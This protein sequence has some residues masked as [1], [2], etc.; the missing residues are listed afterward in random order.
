M[1][2]YQSRFSVEGGLVNHGEIS[3]KKPFSLKT[4][5]ARD[6]EAL[7]TYHVSVDPKP[8]EYKYLLNKYNV[9]LTGALKQFAQGRFIYQRLILFFVVS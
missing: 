4:F 9:Y 2:G 1:T 8:A 7:Q 5:T 3:G 6:F